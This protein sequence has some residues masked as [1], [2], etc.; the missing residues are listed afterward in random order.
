MSQIKV[1]V[2]EEGALP[3]DTELAGIV[4]MALQDEQ[5]A[6][7]NDIA[8]N[9]QREP[10]L[11]WKGKVVDGRCRQKALIALQR[12]ILYKEL[13]DSLT[14]EDVRCLVKSMNTRRNLTSTQKIASAAKEYESEDNQKSVKQLAE[15]WGISVS[16]LENAVWLQRK[17]PIVIDSLFNGLSVP[18]ENIH[19]IKVT[20][21]KVSAI[22]AY[23]KRE[24][25]QAKEVKENGWSSKTSIT[26][27]AGKDWYYS[28][29]RELP[30][31]NLSMQLTNLLVELTN[32]K[33]K[34]TGEDDAPTI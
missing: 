31:K 19:G 2:V 33:F 24:E 16:I 22:Y 6:L 1:R 26:T 15:S 17:Y 11:L 27:Q 9:G 29:L 25:Q 7:L 20:S 13:D 3:I 4:P 5:T 28:V 14:K 8:A 23:Y 10:I 12:H 32:F 18:I 30:E 34:Q 21:N